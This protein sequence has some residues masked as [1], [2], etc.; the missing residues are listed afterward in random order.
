[1]WE[2]HTKPFDKDCHYGS[3]FKYITNAQ[4]G[5]GRT[6]LYDGKQHAVVGSVQPRGLLEN[7]SCSVKLTFVCFLLFPLANSVRLF[8]G[9]RLA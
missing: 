9:V 6:T 4:K 1:V 2:G 8:S 7:I 5:G 3:I